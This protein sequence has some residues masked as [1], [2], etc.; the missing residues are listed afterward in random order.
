MGCDSNGPLTP[1]SST[2]REEWEELQGHG[3]AAQHDVV[4]E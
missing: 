3:K 1:V 2:D 4:W